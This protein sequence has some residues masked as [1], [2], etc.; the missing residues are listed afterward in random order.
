MSNHITSQVLGQLVQDNQFKDWW[1][2]DNISIPLFDNKSMPITFMN[3]EPEVDKKFIAEA[4]IAFTNF[5]NLS[6]SDKAVLTEIVYRNYIDTINAIGR[7]NVKP[8]LADLKN[9]EGVWDFVNPTEIFI[10][11]RHRR[12]MDIYIS[13]SCGCDWEEEHGLELIFRQGKKLTKIG[14]HDGHLTESDAYDIPDDQDELL[15]KF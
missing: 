11:R 9:K 4:D 3:F 8:E 15:S 2:I 10:T 5:L 12:D 6:N 13:V 7:D 14:G 1:I